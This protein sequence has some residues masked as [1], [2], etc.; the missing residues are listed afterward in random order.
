MVSR[1]GVPTDNP[2]SRL[3]PPPQSVAA[4]PHFRLLI[5]V[6]PRPASGLPTGRPGLQGCQPDGAST[7][8]VLPTLLARP[9]LP[10]PSTSEGS[11]RVTADRG[12]AAQHNTG[13][14]FHCQSRI[15]GKDRRGVGVVLVTMYRY[16]NP[17]QRSYLITWHN[18]CVVNEEQL[19][20]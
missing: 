17:L 5:D 20:C 18:V 8:A 12:G 9:A 4:T 6:S 16:L 7:P 1:I 3:P 19:D 13:R 10:C 15:R 14:Y 2:N 11:R